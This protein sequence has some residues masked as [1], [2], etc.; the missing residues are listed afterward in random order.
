MQFYSK[1]AL[2]LIKLSLILKFSKLWRIQVSTFNAVCLS[3][4]PAK[5]LHRLSRLVGI[6]SQLHITKQTKNTMTECRFRNINQSMDNCKKMNYY[7]CG[8]RE[9]PTSAG[10]EGALAGRE[11]IWKYQAGAWKNI[12]DS[13][14][15]LGRT[16]EQIQSIP[17]IILQIIDTD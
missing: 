11:N 3:S 6:I 9:M 14:W 16:E 12:N 1:M 8:C 10:T 7:E 17:S 15:S 2:V 13:G 4:I 5:T